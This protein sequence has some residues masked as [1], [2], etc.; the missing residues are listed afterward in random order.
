MKKIPKQYAGIV[1]SFYASAIMVLIVSGVLVALN[2]GVDAGYPA[3]LVRAYAITWPVAFVSL[4]AVRPLVMKL[5]AWS[6]SH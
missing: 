3:R 2:T 6:T 5:V 1:F 4:L